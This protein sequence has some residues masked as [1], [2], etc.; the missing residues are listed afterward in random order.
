MT[1]LFFHFDGTNNGPED[2]YSRPDQDESISNVLKSHLLMG[3]GL[4][5][6]DGRLGVCSPNRSFYYSGIGTYGSPLERWLNASFAFENADVAQILS[7]ALLDFQCHYHDAIDKIVLIGFSRGAALA[8]R[9]ASL[10]N[11]YVAKPIVIEA[12]IDTVASIGLPN[13]DPTKRPTNEV[14]FEDGGQ[15]PNCVGAALH[16]LALDEQR[17]AFRPTLMNLDPRVSEVWSPGVHSDVGGGYR[18]DCLADLSFSVMSNWLHKKLNLDKTCLYFRVDQLALLNTDSDSCRHWS[19]LLE[20]T[21]SITGKIHLQHR[22][23][24]LADATLAPRMCFVWR[25]NKPC[26]ISPPLWHQSVFKRMLQNPNY[27]PA[28]S[29]STPPLGWVM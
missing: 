26:P 6:A 17:L 8:R 28:A 11:P 12:V 1:I 18:K 15:L 14:V 24:T 21:P 5:T 27:R 13:L 20:M 16:L 4:K 7:R 29:L 19:R 2:A 25:D 3:G 9:F 10:I 23:R 22:P